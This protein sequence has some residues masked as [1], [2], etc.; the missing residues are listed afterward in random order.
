[1]FFISDLGPEAGLSERLRFGSL[2]FQK[3]ALANGL[4]AT[5]VKSKLS[6]KPQKPARLSPEPEGHFSAL[7]REISTALQ[8][9]INL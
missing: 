9:T 4:N 6:K 8:S 7:L 3:R 1:M 5:I 2:L